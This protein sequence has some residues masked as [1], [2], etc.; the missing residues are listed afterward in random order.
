MNAEVAETDIKE[1]ARGVEKSSRN[2]G[3]TADSPSPIN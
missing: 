1:N 2:S 3:K